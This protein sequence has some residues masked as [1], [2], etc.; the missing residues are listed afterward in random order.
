MNGHDEDDDEVIAEFDV[1][2]AGQMRDDIHLLQYPL[3][4]SY[5]PYGD[6]GELVKVEMAV[7]HQQA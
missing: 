4:P 1:V 2:L 6:Q 5:R 3:R 7:T